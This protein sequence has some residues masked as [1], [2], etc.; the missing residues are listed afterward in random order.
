[1]N[2][3]EENLRAESIKR[4]F[5]I[6]YKNHCDFLKIFNESYLPK[7]EKLEEDE[8]KNMKTWLKEY[9][10]MTKIIQNHILEFEEYGSEKE[11]PDEDLLIKQATTIMMFLKFFREPEEYFDENANPNGT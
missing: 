5:K 7:I 11:F 6:I 1:M 3:F 9:S 10:R 4:D 2:N 8:Y